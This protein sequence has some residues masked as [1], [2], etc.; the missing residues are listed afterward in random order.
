[1]GH[2]SKSQGKGKCCCLD[3]NSLNQI[4]PFMQKAVNDKLVPSAFSVNSC[5]CGKT[6]A[7]YAGYRD[8]NNPSK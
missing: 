6:N 5:K 2:K 1:M 3:N 7:Y 4:Q 8:F